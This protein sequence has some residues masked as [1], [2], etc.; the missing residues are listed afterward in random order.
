MIACVWLVSSLAGQGPGSAIRPTGGRSTPCRRLLFL[1]VAHRAR[2]RPRKAPRVPTESGPAR[3]DP[4]LTEGFRRKVKTK[5][6]TCRDYLVYCVVRLAISTVQA[7][8]M[9]TC[10]LAARMLATL[11]TTVAPVRRHVI[12]E[13]LRQAYPHMNTARRRRLAWKMWEHL[14]LMV[15]ELA[16]ARRKIHVTNWHRH[17]KLRNGPQLARLLLEDRPTVLVGGHF[18]NFEMSCYFLGLFGFSTYAIARPLDN[19]FLHRYINQFRVSSGQYMLA[20]NGSAKQIALLLERG[21]TLALLGDQH[22]GHRAC[23]VDFFGRPAST[24]KAIAL[25]C[26]TAGAPL[27]VSFARRLNEPLVY[28]SAIAGV[29]DPN[30]PAVRDSSISELTQWYTDRLEQIINQSPEQYWWV[31]R[32]WKGEPPSGWQSLKNRPEAA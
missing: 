22:A 32:R 1:C 20:K 30:E 26:L 9:E 19:R 5:L 23:W 10:R 4:S 3:L 14:F 31:H 18:G 15:A 13:N 27:V 29:A 7:L 28:E 2:I 25:F 6:T 16:H 21:A 24:H 8:R 12:E 11:F 17:I